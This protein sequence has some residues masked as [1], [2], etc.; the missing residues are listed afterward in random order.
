M[1]MATRLPTLLLGALAAAGLVGAQDGYVL[2]LVY[3]LS[4]TVI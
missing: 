1:A 4:I 2:F 3:V